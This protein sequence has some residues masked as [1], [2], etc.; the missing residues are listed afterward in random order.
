[1]DLARFFNK[2]NDKEFYMMK[3]YLKNK[4][5]AIKRITRD[6]EGIL[7]AE[8]S[9][10]F[11]LICFLIKEMIRSLTVNLATQEIISTFPS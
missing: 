1:M 9:D 11:L 8:D 3:I 7:H 10:K 5:H 2:E 4:K 6:L